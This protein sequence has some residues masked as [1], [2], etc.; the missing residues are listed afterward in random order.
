MKV[1]PRVTAISVAVALILLPFESLAAPG[2]PSFVIASKSAPGSLANEASVEVSGDKPAELMSYTVTVTS[3]GQSDIKKTVTLPSGAPKWNIPIL[4]LTGGTTYLFTVTATD[5]GGLSTSSDAVSFKAQSVPDS[6]TGVIAEAG[7]ENVK[8]SWTPPSDRGSTLS[9]YTIVALGKTYSAAG[10][11]TTKTIPALTT[12]TKYTFTITADNSIGSSSVAT[13]N[14]VSVIGKPGAPGKPTLVLD[15]SNLKVTWTTPSDSGLGTLSGYTVTAVPDSGTTLTSDVT[16]VT[17]ATFTSIPAHTW[18]ATVTAKNEFYTSDSSATSDP[19]TTLTS[20]T[21]D[22]PVIADQKAPGTITVTATATS[23]LVVTF[24]V[25]GDCTLA[26]SNK[27]S[28]TGGNSCTVTASQSG[29]GTYNPATSF[30]RK[31]NITGGTDLS[32]GGGGDGGGAPIPVVPPTPIPTPLASPQKAAPTA[33]PIP[34]FM[35]T[36]APTPAPTIS[37]LPVPSPSSTGTNS[38]FEISKVTGKPSTTSRVISNTKSLALSKGKTLQLVIPAVPKGSTFKAIIKTPDG[39]SVSVLTFKTKKNGDVTI[40]TLNFKK[41]GTYVVTVTFGKI[42]KVITI[43]VSNPV[44]KKVVSKVVVTKSPVVKPATTTLTVTC[45]DGK[46]TRT[47]TSK[48][49]QCP[50]GFHR[51]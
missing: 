44:V 26:N 19:L 36:P 2:I 43:N 9:S 51:K 6:P 7:K 41:P 30:E 22:F 21:I 32:G 15:G 40:P 45:T 37:A 11:A 38:F 46:A 14:Q 23:G 1:A 20:Q 24:S 3:T 33:T 10:T 47:V 17:T 8:L 28:F 27:V 12:G 35:A 48:A 34:T 13:F 42:K 4:G 16:G 39:K 49:P 29:N 18:T 50:S 25:S 31:F 5:G